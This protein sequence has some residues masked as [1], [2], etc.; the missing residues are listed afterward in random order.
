MQG[1]FIGFNTAGST[2]GERFL[3]MLLKVKK[4]NGFCEI[5]YLLAPALVV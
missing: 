4:V 3:A 5:Y 1:T 2:F